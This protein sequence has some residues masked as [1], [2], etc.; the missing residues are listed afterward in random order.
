VSISAKTYEFP[1][2][3]RWL[4]G[5]LTIAS[6]SGKPN[7]EVA[8][9]PEF[10]QGIAGVWSPEDLLVTSAAACFAVT[11]LAIAERRGVP[12]RGLDAA[13]R[14]FVTQRSDGPFAFTRI[15][16]EVELV[17]EAGFEHDAREAADAAERGC[18]I[19]ASLDLPIEVDLDVHAVQVSET[20]A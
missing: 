9:P 12:V 3:V 7:L 19:A 2:D 8:T 13:A 5:R 15:Q 17:T 16:L 18:L 20:S 1:V 4:E 11:L 6:A 14:G 10:K